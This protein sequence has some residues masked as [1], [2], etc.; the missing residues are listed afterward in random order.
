MKFDQLVILAASSSFS[1]TF[2]AWPKEYVSLLRLGNSIDIDVCP[3]CRVD[4]RWTKTSNKA[5]EL[6]ENFLLDGEP[7]VAWVRVYRD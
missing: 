6:L 4:Y 3:F 2:P 1:A 7:A 5:C